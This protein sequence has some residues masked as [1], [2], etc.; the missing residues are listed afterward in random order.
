MRFGDFH[1]LITYTAIVNASFW[2]L[3]Y[4]SI[5]NQS[6][7]IDFSCLIIFDNLSLVGYLFPVTVFD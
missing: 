5:Y 2:V 4:S 7:E 6:Q 1:V 3:W